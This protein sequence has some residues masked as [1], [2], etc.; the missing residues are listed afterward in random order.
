LKKLLALGMLGLLV[1]FAMAL[2]TSAT[3]RDYDATARSV[4]I[5]VT[6]DDSELIDLTP[7]EPYAYINGTGHLVIDFSKNNPNWPGWQ[8][9]TWW[10]GETPI[11]GLGLS[12]Q[13]RYNFDE[14]FNVSNHLWEEFDIVVLI[15]SSNSMIKFYNPLTPY[16]MFDMSG[17]ALYASDESSQV[18]CFILAPGE[19]L[20]VGMEIVNTNLGS[21]DVDITIKAWPLSDAPAYLPEECG[22]DQ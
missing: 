10:D 6:S 12:P 4:H 5:W 2:G 21:Y 22:G 13:S 18:A 9:A 11:K 14:V 17:D 16:E 8:N 3:F 15:N 7:V 20:G 1:A 19:A